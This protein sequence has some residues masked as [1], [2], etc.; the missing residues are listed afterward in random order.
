MK[1]K[2]FGMYKYKCCTFSRWPLPSWW[3]PWW[4][5]SRCPH[6]TR[7]SQR[8]LPLPSSVGVA[9][10]WVYLYHPSHVRALFDRACDVTGRRPC[11]A[12]PEG[13]WDWDPR[14]GYV[15]QRVPGYRQ[16]RVRHTNLCWRARRQL[17]IVQREFLKH[18][19][20][21]LMANYFGNF[22]LLART[23]IHVTQI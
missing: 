17:G 14:P 18:Y 5:R 12:H 13:G 2:M 4:L 15:R 7:R 19:L 11:V 1:N 8:V 10:P 16:E 3:P 22:Y 21:L 6:K 23:F 20:K 9:P